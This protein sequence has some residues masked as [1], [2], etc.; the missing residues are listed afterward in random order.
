MHSI[1][2]ES[3]RDTSNRSLP[4]VSG[5]VLVLCLTAERRKHMGHQDNQTFQ[6]YIGHISGVDMSNIA[7][8]RAQR[9]A[10][11][12]QLRSMIVERIESDD[13]QDLSIENAESSITTEIMEDLSKEANSTIVVPTRVFTR[14]QKSVLA[15]SPARARLVDNFYKAPTSNLT[16]CAEPLLELSLPGAESTFYPG[17]S[18][19]DGLKCPICSASL[20]SVLADSDMRG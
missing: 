14:L 12:N 13:F 19:T 11:F 20:I 5:G 7:E 10:L 17:L 16:S 9:M 6:H 2:W 4:T 18:L 1:P 15:Y 3:E 8:G